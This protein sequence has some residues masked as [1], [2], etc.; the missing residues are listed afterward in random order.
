MELVLVRHA[1]PLWS[2]KHRAQSDPGLS[3]LGRRQAKL[4]ARRLAQMTFDGLYASTAVRAQETAA[5]ITTALGRAAHDQGWLHEI[6]FPTAWHGTPAE[7]VSRLLSEA[8]HRPRSEWW[9]GVPGGESFR[10]FHERVC[11]GL[12][13]LLEQ[14]G[15]RRP[16]PDDR[17]WEVPD[18][19]LRLLLIAHG[20]T[21]SI[22]LGHLLGLEP[23]PWE[24]ER[25]ASAHASLTVLR[26]VG[27]AGSHIWSLQRFSDVGHLDD[28]LISA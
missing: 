25:F 8:R 26:T 20:G 21:N 9:E 16:D 6:R 23:E 3:D 14:C 7:E 11:L 24:W 27:I 10:D 15:A 5:P 28:E 17:L 12:V 2:R 18:E 19:P 22:V 13:E 4:V 1:Q